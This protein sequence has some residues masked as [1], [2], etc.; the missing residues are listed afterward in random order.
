MFADALL[1]VVVYWTAIDVNLSSASVV[2]TWHQLA[3]S[4]FTTARR[5]NQ[6]DRLALAYLER[7]IA[8]NLA[9]TVVCE[10]YTSKLY[11]VAELAQRNSLW[12][13]LHLALGVDD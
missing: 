13:I 11:L 8:Q 2:E 1:R 9:L 10:V 12:L 5:A 4:R 3:Q 6:S 7:Y